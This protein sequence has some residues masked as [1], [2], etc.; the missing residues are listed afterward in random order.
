MFAIVEIAGKQFEVSEK[1]VVK[2]PYLGKD[3]GTKVEFDKVLLID[4]NGAT[5]V[6]TPAIEGKKVTATVV[7]NDREKK[8][9]VFK[10]KRRT[11][12]RRK[13]GHRQDFTLVQINGIA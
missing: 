6:G 11:T 10:K 2:V 4:D 9:I 5:T 13:K 12:Y 7:K 8:I 3:L 1:K